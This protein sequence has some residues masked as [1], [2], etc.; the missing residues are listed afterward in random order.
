MPETVIVQV[1]MSLVKARDLTPAEILMA[2][3]RPLL[4]TT[5]PLPPTVAR[6]VA[7]PSLLAWAVPQAAPTSAIPAKSGRLN[8]KFLINCFMLR[9][10]IQ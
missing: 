8:R 3:V 9:S 10:S 5:V 7:K 6:N 2:L 4:L 1:E